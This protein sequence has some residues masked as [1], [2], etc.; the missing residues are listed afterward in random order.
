MSMLRTARHVAQ[1]GQ[2]KLV[3]VFT[4]GLGQLAHLLRR[5]ALR[6]DQLILHANHDGADGLLLARQRGAKL[7]QNAAQQCFLHDDLGLEDQVFV[8]HGFEGLLREVQQNIAIGRARGEAHP[9]LW[10][11]AA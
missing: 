11:E 7:H 3:E 5:L 2:G 4:R 9:R 10:R 6:C 8:V 1:Q